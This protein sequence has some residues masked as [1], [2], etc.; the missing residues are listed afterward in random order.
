MTK[1]HELA[2][3][4]QSIWYDNIRRALI[5]SGELQTLLDAGVT[6]VTSNPSIFEKAIAESADYDDAIQVMAAD[7]KSAEEICEALVI[8]D[9]QRT[10]DLL[11]PIY[12]STGGVDGYVS[13]EVSPMLAHDTAGTFD[14]RVQHDSSDDF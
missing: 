11:R 10:A 8:D 2:N 12:D 13:L 9:I 1:L 14:W 3:H 6:G 4:V 5:D 7:G